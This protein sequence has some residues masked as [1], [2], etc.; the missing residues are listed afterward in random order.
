MNKVQGRK[1]M[2]YHA[3]ESTVALET[4]TMP[5]IS[6][7]GGEKTLV[8][9]PGLRTSGIE[10]SAVFVAWYYRMFAREY[11]VYLFDRKDALPDRV[12]IHGLAED[13]AEA[14]NRLGLSNAYVYGASQGGMIAQDLAVHHPELVKKLVLAVT[15]S[16]TNATAET[17][18]HHWI[19]LIERDAVQEMAAD[20]MYKGCSEAYLK[21][22]KAAVPWLTKLQKTMPKDR[23]L[24]LT[25][26]CLTCD[27]YDQLDRIQCPV[28]V[29]GG[30]KDQI[31]TGEASLEIARKLNCEYYIYEDLSH[32]AYNEAKDFNQRIYE[33]FQKP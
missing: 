29:L 7:G 21:R 22:Y 24:K 25:R 19:D 32:E 5:Y 12:T 30:G 11:T 14:M 8:I 28:L 15:L 26:S 18:I 16:R 6:F 3:K 23:L 1:E 27:T 17:V 33:F 4:G 13:T 9:I 2:L 20:Y 31:V 10:G